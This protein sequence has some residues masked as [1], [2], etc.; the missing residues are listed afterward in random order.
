M[1]ILGSDRVAFS[2]NGIAF[3]ILEMLKPH[4]ISEITYYFR[5]ERNYAFTQF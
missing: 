1:K 2:Y 4:K 3:E 5:N